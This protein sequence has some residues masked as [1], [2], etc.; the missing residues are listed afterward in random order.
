[1]KTKSKA[2]LQRYADFVEE[3]KFAFVIDALAKREL[4]TAVMLAPDRAM[5]DELEDAGNLTVRLMR[6]DLG[7]AMRGFVAEGADLLFKQKGK[8][9]GYRFLQSAADYLVDHFLLHFDNLGHVLRLRWMADLLQA[10]SVR[11]YDSLARRFAKAF[12]IDPENPTAPYDPGP[13]PHV[14][15]DKVVSALVERQRAAHH[16]N[17]AP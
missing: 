1:M 14:L 11:D 2:Q 8:T 10:I 4:P 5:A 17:V 15:R 12:Q 13:H 16:G 6:C 7:I 3:A 9:Y